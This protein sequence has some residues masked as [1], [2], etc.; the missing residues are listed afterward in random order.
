MKYDAICGG[1]ELEFGKVAGVELGVELG[2]RPCELADW[3]DEVRC[4][5]NFFC[6][7]NVDG[8]AEE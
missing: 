3:R 4:E 7:D 6:L 5:P 2:W 1:D 8:C